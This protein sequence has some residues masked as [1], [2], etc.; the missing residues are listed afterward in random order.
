MTL[1]EILQG[2]NVAL[3]LIQARL[4]TLLALVF[5]FALYAWAMWQQTLLGASICAIWGLTIFLPIL[6]IGR[7]GSDATQRQSQRSADEP[8]AGSP[9]GA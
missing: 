4:L 3:R 1:I 2:A 9:D 7:G 8:A 6:V 5:T